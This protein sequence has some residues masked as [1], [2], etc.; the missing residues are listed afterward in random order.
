MRVERRFLST[1][2]PRSRL[3]VAEL[4]LRRSSV[5]RYRFR[6]GN[7]R[8]S[9]GHC[10]F[11]VLGEPHPESPVHHRWVPSPRLTKTDSPFALTIGTTTSNPTAPPRGL[12]LTSNCSSVAYVPSK[13]T[14]RQRRSSLHDVPAPSKSPKATGVWSKF[15]SIRS[16]SATAWPRLSHC[17][18]PNIVVMAAKRTATPKPEIHFAVKAWRNMLMSLAPVA[19][20]S[21]GSFVLRGNQQRSP[22]VPDTRPRPSRDPRRGSVGFATRCAHRPAPDILSESK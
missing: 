6:P 5:L 16:I 22:D 1:V 18:S 7:N 19:V 8:A 17:H 3:M 9:D 12:V 2:P 20:Y 21:Q 4:S 14:G 11:L 15:V 10:A 13:T